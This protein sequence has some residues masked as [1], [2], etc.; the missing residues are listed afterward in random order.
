MIQSGRR[1]TTPEENTDFGQKQAAT[2]ETQKKSVFDPCF[3][4]G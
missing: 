1:G 2:D 4:C 3:I